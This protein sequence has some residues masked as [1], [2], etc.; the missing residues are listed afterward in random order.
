MNARRAIALF[1][2]GTARPGYGPA[3]RLRHRPF[4]NGII[5]EGT[6]LPASAWGIPALDHSASTA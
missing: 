2:Q 6:T 1:L 5:P 4:A 3:I